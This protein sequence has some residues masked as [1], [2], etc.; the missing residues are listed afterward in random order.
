MS[1]DAERIAD[2]LLSQPSIAIVELPT[3]L[4]G[5]VE[6]EMPWWEMADA[7]IIV[8]VD[9]HGWVRLNSQALETYEARQLARRLL[10][11]ANAAEQPTIAR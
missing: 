9:P 3:P 11:A 1:G 2:V 6:G 7:E 4:P 5:G 10:A 8:R